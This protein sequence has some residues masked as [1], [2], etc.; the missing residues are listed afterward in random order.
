MYSYFAMAT[1][2]FAEYYVRRHLIVA[3]N[4]AEKD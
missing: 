2:V 3:D 1:A 4:A